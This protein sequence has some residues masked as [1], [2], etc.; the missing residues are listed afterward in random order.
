VKI[1]TVSD[2]EVNLLYSPRIQERCADV[3]LIL[4]CGDLPYYYLE[5]VVSMLDVPLVYVLGNHH[6]QAED[7][8][9]G[10]HRYPEGG[11]NLHRR[12]HRE[13]GLLLAGIE[14]SL[15]YNN[16]AGQY[17]QSEMW[18]AVWS[19]VPGLLLN[20]LRFGR[21]LDVLITHAP[22]WKIQDGADRPHQGVKAFVWLD[23]VFKPAVH[24]HGHT[25]QYR[26]DARLE[27]AFHETTVVNTFGYRV[28]EL[29]PGRRLAGQSG[30]V[31]RG[32]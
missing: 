31:V 15:R 29:F 12:T 14:G 5:Y 19:L 22:P 9:T 13:E 4:S 1:L 3:D 21:Y 26:L 30:L 32:W 8:I 20:R 28:T 10:S 7:G 27:T 11:T 16:G 25:H 23:R 18:M 2:V 24:F 6:N 17:S